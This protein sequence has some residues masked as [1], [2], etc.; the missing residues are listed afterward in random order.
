MPDQNRCLFSVTGKNYRKKMQMGSQILKKTWLIVKFNFRW[1]KINQC[2]H[3]FVKCWREHVVLLKID[4]YW[5]IDDRYDTMS[6]FV[7]YP[8]ELSVTVEVTNPTY[9]SDLSRPSTSLASDAEVVP[10]KSSNNFS[11][12]K[13][14]C[15]SQPRKSLVTNSVK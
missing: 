9:D 5:R 14:R 15:T 13:T 10:T 1:T 7:V 6:H 12:A 8:N 2:T 3:Q 11:E 4:I